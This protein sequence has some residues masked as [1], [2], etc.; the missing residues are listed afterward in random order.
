MLVI[1][2]DGNCVPIAKGD[3]QARLI[4]FYCPEGSYNPLATLV[5]NT[6]GGT[7][8]QFFRFPILLADPGTDYHIVPSLIAYF[9]AW[10]FLTILTY[11]VWVPAG[12]FVPGI[13][14]GC[15]LGT[16]YLELLVNGLGASTY[17]V[18]T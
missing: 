14:L 7:I 17:R 18:G 3:N 10:Y 15:T 16:L 11:G 12:I 5:F 1:I 4:P 9:F 6:E 2:W 8:R 13:L